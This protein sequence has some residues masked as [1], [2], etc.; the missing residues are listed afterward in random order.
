MEPTHWLIV[1]FLDF[2]T[3]FFTHFDGVHLIKPLHMPG[4]KVSVL[5]KEKDVEYLPRCKDCTEE[6]T[7]AANTLDNIGLLIFEDDSVVKSKGKSNSI[8]VS[9][10]VSF[11]IFL[12]G[13]YIEARETSK[14][15]A[16]VIEVV[17]S[18]LIYQN[19][20]FVVGRL[21]QNGSVL[22]HLSV[23]P[24]ISLKRIIIFWVFITYERSLFSDGNKHLLFIWNACI[25]L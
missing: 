24:L 1:C 11:F 13:I 10:W 14:H 12:D 4:L 15:T 2:L 8:I 18:D 16:R 21:F 19:L 5:V 23:V 22:L 25:V 17:N 6:T 3:I 20:C 7:H 9:I